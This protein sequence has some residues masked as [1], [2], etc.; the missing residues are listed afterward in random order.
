M[1]S[2][3]GYPSRGTELETAQW[4]NSNGNPRNIFIYGKTV[5]FCFTYNKTN[6]LTNNDRA[7]PRFVP[8][9]V[10]RIIII[11]IGIVKSFLEYLNSEKSNFLISKSPLL[12]NVFG[13]DVDGE[14][15]RHFFCDQF[16]KHSSKKIEFRHFRH[17]V[18]SFGLRF[19]NFNFVTNDREDSFL[20][21]FALQAGHSKNMACRYGSKSKDLA[22]VTREKLY[23]LYSVSVRWHNLLGF[24]KE[25]ADSPRKTTII[26]PVDLRD[27]AL[28]KQ[29]ENDYSENNFIEKGKMI[30]KRVFKINNFNS[31]EQ[32]TAFRLLFFK[33]HDVLINF[34]PGYG[35]TLPILLCCSM[36]TGASIFIV[37][38]LALQNDLLNNC[39]KIGISVGVYDENFIYNGQCYECNISLTNKA[40]KPHL[41]SSLVK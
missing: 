29:D 39:R 35:K 7:I 34:P 30:L 15:I 20:D 16:F 27:A 17:I 19:L 3:Y 38:L 41:T 1:H 33:K 26:E 13:K 25:I 21:D 23:S 40:F 5:C 10:A 2:T 9:E 4:V 12:F 32:E 28:G 24:D 36:E 8:E 14:E 37:P 22:N 18:E 6:N 31:D 11:Y